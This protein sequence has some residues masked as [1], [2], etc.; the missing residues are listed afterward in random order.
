M[1]KQED[2]YPTYIE[3]SFIF[4]NE[5]TENLKH[6]IEELK[7]DL[8]KDYNFR[9]GF[10]SQKNNRNTHEE[11][12]LRKLLNGLICEN[13][14][15]R[16]DL[17][18][19]IIIVKKLE[20]EALVFREDSS[21]PL[22]IKVNNMLNDVLEAEEKLAQERLNT[23]RLTNMRQTEIKGE[24]ILHNRMKEMDRTYSRITKHY[25][26]LKQNNFTAKN[27]AA[28]VEIQK[29]LYEEAVC[30]SQI[31]FKNNFK[32]LN[33]VK[34]NLC[35]E[36]SDLIGRL[37][38]ENLKNQVKSS[39]NKLLLED[40]HNEFN[41]YKDCHTNILNMRHTLSEYQKKFKIIYEVMQRTGHDVSLSEN[42]HLGD[43]CKII[44]WHNMMNF[45]EFSL[46]AKY[47]EL[48]ASESKKNT[49]LIELRKEFEKMQE[50][51]S[52]FLNMS[53]RST[54]RQQKSKLKRSS[55][56]RIISAHKSEENSLKFLFQLFQVLDNYLPYLEIIELNSQSKS[57]EVKSLLD[58]LKEILEG[59]RKGNLKRNIGQTTRKI[60]RSHTQKILITLTKTSSQENLYDEFFRYIPLSVN[61]IVLELQEIF[62][63]NYKEIKDFVK[64]VKDNKVIRTFLG[65]EVLK[66]LKN[67]DSNHSFYNLGVINSE[68]HK[69]LK[70]Y[71]EQ[72]IDLSSTV[73]ITI[74]K[75]SKELN[76]E[77]NSNDN[78][79][80]N[81]EET[82]LDEFKFRQKITRRN[83]KIISKPPS[84]YKIIEKT[85]RNHTK[86]EHST[87]EEVLNP[88][89]IDLPEI[90]NIDKY[91]ERKHTRSASEIPDDKAKS[92]RRAH[93]VLQ[94]VKAL[95]KKMMTLKFQEK[96]VSKDQARYKSDDIKIP[97]K[98][99]I[100]KDQ[101]LTSS[102]SSKIETLRVF[103]HPKDS[104]T[105]R[106][107]NMSSLTIRKHN[108]TNSVDLPIRSQLINQ[109]RK[110]F[111]F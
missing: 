32:K 69:I 95:D 107:N 55:N 98:F 100:Q 19:I 26:S 2:Q 102:R 63:H 65:K 21:N 48:M 36:T 45:Q 73:F 20:Q 66:R 76:I 23:E 5:N 11:I 89:K 70:L 25:I 93:S 52:D 96:V 29:N 109:L 59:V 104:K 33:Y 85:S 81:N 58:E 51:N 3:D 106:N 24:M 62:P 94:E 82:F 80:L 54:Y 38:L 41:S 72:L 88:H 28:V 79:I 46:S 64:Y 87:L 103:L 83:S 7:S 13:N 42:I 84:P 110:T 99:L 49:Q 50:S 37:S 77:L 10:E 91:L 97:R 60:R 12:K 74:K 9:E 71:F 31:D 35:K 111:K 68:S 75:I 6:E 4:D 108:R 30:K 22:Q 61:E 27:N 34:G 14:K 67:L 43:V 15:R 47:Q 78:L 92:A 56:T 17:Q 57:N 90:E 86:I 40:L 8:Q 1:L 101:E 105:S 53:P 39:S 44:E 18:E 16:H